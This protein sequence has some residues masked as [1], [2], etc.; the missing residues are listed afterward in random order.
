MEFILTPANGRE[1]MRQAWE[2]A[3]RVLER[4]KSVRIRMDEVMPTRTADQNAKMWAVL[5]DVA[6]QVQWPVNGEKVWLDA[7]DWKDLF[8][9][10]LT[11]HHRMAAGL[12][13]GFVILGMR[14]SR[15]KIGEMVDL[16][17]LAHAFGAEHGVRWSVE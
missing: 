4:G 17:E 16:I 2:Q 14:T 7:E 8:T 12:Q 6:T 11:K 10:A 3:C 5:R 1:R 15:M 13:G 9:A